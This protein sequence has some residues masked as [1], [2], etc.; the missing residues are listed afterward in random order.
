MSACCV[1]QHAARR[2]GNECRYRASWSWC[3]PQDDGVS[4]MP[5]RS[6][7]LSTLSRAFQQGGA[8]RHADAWR[9]DTLHRSD[10]ELLTAVRAGDSH[11]FAALYREH[12]YAVRKGTYHLVDAVQDAFARELQH[13]AD[14]RESDRFRPWLLAIARHG[15]TDQLRARRRVTALDE[16]A[17][18]NLAAGGP[19]PES[20]ADQV[21]GCVVRLSRPDAVAVTMVTSRLRIGAPGGRPGV[22][23]GTA[24]VI[25]HRARRSSRPRLCGVPGPVGR[26]S[27]G[28]IE[29]HRGVSGAGGSPGPTA[30]G[31]IHIRPARMTRISSR[32]A[33]RPSS[34]RPVPPRP[35]RRAARRDR[36]RH[37]VVP[38]RP[39]LGRVTTGRCRREGGGGSGPGCRG[40]AGPGW[41]VGG[42]IGR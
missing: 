8:Y 4:A 22:R 27:A 24:K 34:R 19:R 12:A 41:V 3:Y 39:R 25:V 38:D 14:L 37:R 35:A 20:V 6:R 30:R 29:A 33:P 26:G 16:N 40:R 36:R 28:G 31:R 7:A 17:E 15:A 10:A 32:R 13:L 23:Q 21:R 11:A 18:E 42:A 2:S 1:P 9:P 5:Q